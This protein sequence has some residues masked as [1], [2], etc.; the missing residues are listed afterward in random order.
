MHEAES[1]TRLVLPLS[2]EI[3]RNRARRRG[4][5][6]QLLGGALIGYGIVG[7]AIFIVVATAINTPLER[8]RELTQSVEEQRAA[9]IASMDQGETTI[10]DMATGV[11]RMDTSLANARVATDRSSGIALGVASSMYQL[12][13]AMGITIPIL[14][15]QP[16]LGLSSGF[17]TAGSQLELLSQ[18]LAT[19]G[20][21]LD[22]N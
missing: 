19:I 20:T 22:T 4:R 16:L 7:V 5:R 12:R 6:I 21:S 9:L 8:I 11:R 1:T 3:A 14:G 18:D 2:E 17:D 13:D 10:R 15:G